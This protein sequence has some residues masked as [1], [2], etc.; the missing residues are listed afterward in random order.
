METQFEII[1]GKDRDIEL[2]CLYHRCEVGCRPRRDSWEVRLIPDSSEL[3]L[4]FA[5]S[6]RISRPRSCSRTDTPQSEPTNEANALGNMRTY[7]GN[8]T[9]SI[10]QLEVIHRCVRT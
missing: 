6:L 7:V 5:L 8:L 1:A 9:N 3:W 4:T 2:W 10:L